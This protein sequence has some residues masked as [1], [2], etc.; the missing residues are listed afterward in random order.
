MSEA[1]CTKLCRQR[2][3]NAYPEMASWFD[4]MKPTCEVCGTHPGSERH[5]RKNRSQGGL[6]VPSNIILACFHCHKFI[7]EHPNRARGEGWG[8]LYPAWEP[9][10]VPIKLWYSIEMLLLDDEGG[11][12]KVDIVSIPVDNA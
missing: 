9:A 7:T 1:S 2:A 6:W 10:E 12:T 5:H 3:L 8:S 11:Y 4:V